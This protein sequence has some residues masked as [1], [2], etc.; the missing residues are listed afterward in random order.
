MKLAE[1]NSLF[2]EMFVLCHT[3]NIVKVEIKLNKLE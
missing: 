3:N 2:G 1:F